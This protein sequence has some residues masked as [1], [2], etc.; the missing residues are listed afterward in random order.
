MMNRSSVI[1]FV[2]FGS[3]VG[4]LR[5]YNITGLKSLPRGVPA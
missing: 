1:S 2:L 5:N 4:N 3:M